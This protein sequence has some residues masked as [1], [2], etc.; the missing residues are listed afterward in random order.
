MDPDAPDHEP[1]PH[2]DSH[3]QSPLWMVTAE[4]RLHQLVEMLSTARAQ[5]LAAP[6]AAVTLRFSRAHLQEVRA[7]FGRMIRGGEARLHRLSGV[8]CQALRLCPFG[9][10]SVVVGEV[11]HTRERFT[12]S[13]A[14]AEP[15]LY[16]QTDL[17]LGTR[18]LQRLRIRDG[19]DWQRTVLIAN[20]V[21]YLPLQLS[22]IGVH[23]L[24]TRIKAEEEIWNKVVDEI[25]DLDALVARDKQLRHLSRYVKDVF[26]IK[27]VTKGPRSAARLQR[28]LEALAFSD[29]L[30][31]ACGVAPGPE[32]GRLCFEEV[33]DYTDGGKKES[34]WQ[35]W[36]SVVRWGQ[37]VFEIQIQPL[38]LYHR[39]REHLTRES[40]T[41]FKA[42]RESL[43]NQ[44]AQAMPL[45]GFYRDLLR[46]L[47]LDPRGEA[48]AP[49]PRLTPPPGHAPALLSPTL[50][51]P[52]APPAIHPG[53]RVVVEP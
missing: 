49:R 37:G 32:T 3:V 24:I 42:R 38:S 30:L 9:L 16:Q 11:E 26:G 12:L 43:R 2:N 28:R 7:A 22:P 41:G 8:L 48:P 39:E 5:I 15:E 20:Y 17:D 53:I 25:F 50:A 29:D 14:L 52:P 44:I 36:K 34:G 40:H 27:L 13:H 1:A 33:K 23:K 21:E 4:P 46:W 31:A 47:F 35:A 19:A 6:D 10:N 45:F 51:Q 18:L